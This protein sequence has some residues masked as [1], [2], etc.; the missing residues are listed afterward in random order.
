MKKLFLS[1]GAAGAL[2]V[3]GAAHAQSDTLQTFVD[4]VQAQAQ[5][6]V[7]AAGVNPH[8]DPMAVAAYV[9]PE[10]QLRDLRVISS[11]GSR[12]TDEEVA[13]TLRGVRVSHVPADLLQ[14]KLTI[15]LGGAGVAL[16]KAQ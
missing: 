14:A 2:L 12:D 9:G 5:S 6:Q 1:L 16:A 10:G 8:N 11:S 13:Q 15:F 3:A 7:T 4:H